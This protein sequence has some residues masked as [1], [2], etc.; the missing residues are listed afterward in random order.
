MKLQIYFTTETLKSGQQIVI[1]TKIRICMLQL[2]ASQYRSST[3][4]KTQQCEKETTTAKPTYLCGCL[5]GVSETE[6]VREVLE[7]KI[8]HSKEYGIQ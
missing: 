2:V 8:C 6:F 4:V 3:S 7:T 5:S 1:P